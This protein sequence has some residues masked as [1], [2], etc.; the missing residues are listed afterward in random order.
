MYFKKIRDGG[1]IVIV[2]IVIATSRGILLSTDKSM[3]AEFGSHVELNRHWVYHLLDQM[4]IQRKATT[5]KSKHVPQ[6]FAQLNKNF[7]DDVSVVEMN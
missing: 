1:V 3:L 5:A 7:L 4:H 2:N 6:D